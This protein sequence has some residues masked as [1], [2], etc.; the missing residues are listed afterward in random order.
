MIFLKFSREK[1]TDFSRICYKYLN[2]PSPPRL[3]K[4]L[5]IHK[6]WTFVATYGHLLFA[7]FQ[8]RWSE[9]RIKGGGLTRQLERPETCCARCQVHHYFYGPWSTLELD[10]FVHQSGSYIMCPNSTAPLIPPEQHCLFVRSRVSLYS[11]S[12]RRNVEHYTDPRTGG[13]VGC[14]FLEE[15]FV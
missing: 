7:R 1:K 5:H 14:S 8:L 13:T 9:P 4:N 15:D 12:A 10:A 3:A 6:F 2:P 11:D